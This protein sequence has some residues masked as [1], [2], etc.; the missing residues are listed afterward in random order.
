MGK[1]TAQKD[2]IKD[3]T[4]DSQVN[5]NFPCRWSP[6]SLKFNIYFTY[7]YIILFYII[8][9]YIKRITINNGTAHLKLP[10]NQ[11]RRAALGRPEIKLLGG[12]GAWTSL[13]SANPWFSFGSPNKKNIRTAQKKRIEHKQKAKRAAGIEGQVLTM[14]KSHTRQIEKNRHNSNGTSQ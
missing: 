3:I 9:L 14:L 11:N 13:R 7:V 6:A 4:N 12:G 8:F 10:K 1:R 2:A 5:S